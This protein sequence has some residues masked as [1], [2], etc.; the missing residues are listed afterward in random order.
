[1]FCLLPADS[2]LVAANEFLRIVWPF[3]NLSGVTVLIYMVEHVNG[4]SRYVVLTY[5]LCSVHNIITFSCLHAG[6]PK[7]C[8]STD[9]SFSCKHSVT[10]TSE[11]Q[12][13]QQVSQDYIYCA[14]LRLHK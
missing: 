2:S 7:L 8:H 12:G 6:E 4:V 9:F 5:S 10:M 13:E 1:M 11:C 14:L 3:A